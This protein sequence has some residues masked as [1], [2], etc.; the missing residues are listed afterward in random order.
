MS[1]EGASDGNL[2]LV[3]KR[4]V[5]REQPPVRGLRIDAALIAK[6]SKCSSSGGRPTA[7]DAKD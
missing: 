4:P 6:R 5:G 2:S 3:E 7:V 1:W